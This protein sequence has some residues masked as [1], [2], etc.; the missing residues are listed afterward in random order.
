MKSP[1]LVQLSKLLSL[2]L[3]HEP[4]R[5][6]L[7]LDAEGFASLEDT[8][9][10][11]RIRLPRATEEDIIAVVE[12]IEPDKRRFSIVDRDIRAN[13]GHTLSE[14]I[15]HEPAIPPAMLLHGT[16]AAALDVILRSGLEPMKRQ[17]VHLTSDREIAGRVGSRRG[18]LVIVD[19]DAGA[20]HAAGVVFYR[21]NESFWLAD[22][23]PAR[24]LSAE[25]QR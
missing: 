14:R 12:T 6:D 10:A 1:D 8:L 17:Y 9:R 16:H 4:H 24:F 25:I 22:R 5:F 18:R 11:V 19:V 21:A 2:M 3:R 23:V 13:Y 20:A 7:L 15:R